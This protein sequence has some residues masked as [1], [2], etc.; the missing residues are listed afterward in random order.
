MKH[1]VL[2]K[3]TPDVSAADKERLIPEIQA[4]FEN[5]VSIDGVHSVE[6]FRNCVDRA[7]RFDIMIVITM[8]PEA[9][10]LYDECEW[11]KRWKTEYADIVE[12]KA[13]FDCM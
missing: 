9:L 6:L 7:N 2:A 11:H 13:I 8:E 3:F 1:H 5:I 10:P 4:L 12:K